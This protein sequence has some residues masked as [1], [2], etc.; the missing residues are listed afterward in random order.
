MK[1]LT[2]EMCGSTDFLKEN[3]VFVCQSCSTKYS[4]EEAKRMMNEG[5]DTA[6]VAGN[7]VARNSAKLDNLYKVARRARE[8][9]NTEQALK[10]YEQLQLEDPDNWEPIFFNAY[11]SAINALNNDK[12]GDS[13]KVV[14]GSVSLGGNYRSGII[15]AINFIGNCLDRTFNIIEKIQEY[16]EQKTAI[17]T[18]NG[19]VEHFSAN[20][21]NIIENEFERMLNE[22][23]KWGDNVEGGFIKGSIMR[24]NNVNQSI[25]MN[26]MVSDLL[27]L[28]QKRKKGIDDLIKRRHF[29]EFWTANQSLKTSLESEKK[30]L[31]EQIEVHN[32]EIKA[33][34]EKTEGYGEMLELQKKVESLTSEKKALG[35]FKLKEKKAVQGQIDSTNNEIAPI[36]AR[37]DSAIREVQKNISSLQSRINDI[38]SE[39]TKPR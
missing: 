23:E 10:F 11:Y 18:V 29:E 39:L 9:A 19:H 17:D 36:Q 25:H 26:S 5:T 32:N 1:K 27:T 30:T 14:G 4:V 28:V 37:I 15:P 20:I 34:P 21:K 24:N 8:D 31:T 2:C 6:V 13:V 22:I 38:D 16:D 7:A 35:I 3:G 33:I 12:P